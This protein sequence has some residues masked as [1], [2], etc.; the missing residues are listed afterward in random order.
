M[1]V[2]FFDAPLDAPG[3]PPA[4]AASFCNMGPP[5]F[6]AAPLLLHLWASSVFSPANQPDRNSPRLIAPLPLFSPPCL[7]RT[8]LFT[9]IPPWSW[10]GRADPSP[11]ES[12]PIRA[13][14]STT[15]GCSFR[16][17]WATQQAISTT[18]SRC[19]LSRTT[20][21]GADTIASVRITEAAL[22]RFRVVPGRAGAWPL[23]PR[24]YG[25]PAWVHEPCRP[26]RAPL[27]TVTS[28]PLEPNHPGVPP[29]PP[30][31]EAARYLH[32][33]GFVPLGIILPR[34]YPAF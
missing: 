9:A 14:S 15:A 17:P 19:T 8:V 32:T 7:A 5:P 3:A 12:P 4:D 21:V 16:P 13:S 10:R 1:R 25:R 11:V 26:A 18:Y 27:R 34:V 20:A 28:P 30:G 22:G 31:K 23:F 29:K 24:R 2:T 6:S 33:G